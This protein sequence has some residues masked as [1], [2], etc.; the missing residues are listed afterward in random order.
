MAQQINLPACQNAKIMYISSS[1]PQYS[2]ILHHKSRKSCE[3]HVQSR[4]A[5]IFVLEDITIKMPERKKISTKEE[6]LPNYSEYAYSDIVDNF[7]EHNRLLELDLNSL[8]C[9]TEYQGEWSLNS[10][11]DQEL[12]DH[13]Y[14]IFYLKKIENIMLMRRWITYFVKQ[15]PTQILLKAKAYL[16]SKK[17]SLE[18]WLRCV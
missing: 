7:S 2:P 14:R 1:Y 15:Y 17:L 8:N 12:N 10:F 9:S 5:A 18:D 16:D 6:M 11:K 4:S 13:L 3:L